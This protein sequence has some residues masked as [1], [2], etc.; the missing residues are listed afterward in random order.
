MNR[1]EN[2]QSFYKDRL[3]KKISGVCA[4]IANGHNFPVWATRLAT[5]LLFFVFPVPVLIGYFVAAMILP[6]KYY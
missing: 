6:A 3:N 2:T 1:F 5:L 4:G